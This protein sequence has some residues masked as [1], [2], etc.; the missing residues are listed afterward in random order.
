V[1][2]ADAEFV[3]ELGSTP[4]SLDGGGVYFETVELVVGVG[5]SVGAAALRAG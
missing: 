3:V 4:L 2:H 5:G 1:T